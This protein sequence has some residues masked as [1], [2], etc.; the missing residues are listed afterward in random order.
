MRDAVAVHR[1][2]RRLLGAV[3]GHV[4]AGLPG[5][6]VA[7]PEGLAPAAAAGPDDDC[8]RAGRQPAAQATALDAVQGTAG[9]LVRLRPVRELGLVPEARL[10]IRR[11]GRRTPHCRGR[12]WCRRLCRHTSGPGSA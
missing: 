4:D 5:P 2:L 9:A 3:D 10:T 6:D 12:R 8:L 11:A 1:L 7:G